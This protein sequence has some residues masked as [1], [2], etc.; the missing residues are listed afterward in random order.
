[1]KKNKKTMGYIEFEVC[2]ETTPV[3]DNFIQCLNEVKEK[4]NE[5][6]SCAKFQVVFAEPIKKID[7]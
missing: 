3:D 2:M 6:F 5:M 4:I 1:M 7:I